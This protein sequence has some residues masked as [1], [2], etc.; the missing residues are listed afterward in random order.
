MLAP[1][2]QVAF[3]NPVF[4]LQS[5]LGTQGDREEETN[6]EILLSMS[7]HPDSKSRKEVTDNP[8]EL[9]IQNGFCFLENERSYFLF[10]VKFKT[11]FRNHQENVSFSAINRVMD[12]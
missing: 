10:P 5:T 12:F 6:R 7:T 8:S 4:R 11:S 1:K 2:D 3:L 9:R